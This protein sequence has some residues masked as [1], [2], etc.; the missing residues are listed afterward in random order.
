V[1]KLE[2]FERTKIIKL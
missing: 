2:D 1:K